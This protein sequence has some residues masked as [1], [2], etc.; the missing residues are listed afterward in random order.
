MLCAINTVGVY[1]LSSSEHWIYIWVLI[2]MYSKAIQKLAGKIGDIE[3]SLPLPYF[4]YILPRSIISKSHHSQ[5]F[6]SLGF[7]EECWPEE[8]SSFV[9]PCSARPPAESMDEY[10]VDRIIAGD[11][12]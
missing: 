5:V 6:Q 3:L 7:G 9:G 10:D 12:G 8:I 4:P 11:I 2:V 1:W